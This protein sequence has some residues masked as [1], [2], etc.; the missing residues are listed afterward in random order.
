[1]SKKRQDSQPAA[2]QSRQAQQAKQPAEKPKPK[3][4]ANRSGLPWHPFWRFLVSLLLVMHLL[5]VFVAPWALTTERALPPNYQ[6]ARGQPDPPARDSPLWQIPIVAESLH[7]FFSPYQNLVYINHG[8]NYFAPD[9]PASSVIRWEVVQPSGEV[10]RG[11]FPNKEQQWP[12]LF[13][14]R[15]MMLADQTPGM[16]ARAGEY[17]ASHVATVYG[18]N[19]SLSLYVHN[20]LTPEEVQGGKALNDAST[21]QFLGSVNG[22]PRLGGKSQPV[23]EEPIVIPG[24]GP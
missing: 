3:P 22:Q 16:D 1:M 14:H 7:W 19:S 15:H 17:C 20:L 8:Y 11:E 13:Y 4:A 6:P 18:G 23:A 24:A 21:Y 9:P 10:V 5:A 12:R 2:Q